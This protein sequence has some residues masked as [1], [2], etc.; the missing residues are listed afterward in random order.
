MHLWGFVADMTSTGIGTEAKNQTR[1]PL[2]HIVGKE[3][4]ANN[5]GQNYVFNNDQVSAQLW[6]QFDAFT[7]YVTD[8]VYKMQLHPQMYLN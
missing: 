8:L 6:M 1:V 7:E 2:I 4:G 3:P 5:A